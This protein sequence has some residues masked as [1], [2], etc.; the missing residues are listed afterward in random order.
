PKCQAVGWKQPRRPTLCAATDA[1]LRPGAWAPIVKAETNNFS[2]LAPGAFIR[3]DRQNRVTIVSPMIE[4]GQ[5]TYTALPMLVADIRDG[6]WLRHMGRHAGSDESAE[7]RSERA[8]AQRRS[9]AYPQPSARR[10]L[11]QKA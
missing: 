7:S 5:G 9:G 8:R 3:I 10:R 4:M 2:R 6:G 11:W 1:S